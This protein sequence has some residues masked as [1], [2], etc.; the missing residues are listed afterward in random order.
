VKRSDT[1]EGGTDQIPAD[2]EATGKQLAKELLLYPRSYLAGVL[3]D[4]IYAFL[5]DRKARRNGSL[6][7]AQSRELRA[8]V[9]FLKQSGIWSNT[10]FEKYLRQKYPEA[11]KAY[12]EFASDLH[13]GK[14]HDRFWLAYVRVLYYYRDEYEKYVEGRA[15]RG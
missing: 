3:F 8:K 5:Y 13:K 1:S 6:T 9:D 11:K 2:T 10:G 14:Y 4:K 12:G 7:L 15:G